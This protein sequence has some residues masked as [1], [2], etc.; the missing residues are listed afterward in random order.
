M[1]RRPLGRDTFCGDM[2]FVPAGDAD[3]EG[4]DDD[5]YLLV[6]THNLREDTSEMLVLSARVRC[7]D[8][9]HAQMSSGVRVTKQFGECKLCVHVV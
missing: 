5:G 4:Q 9:S 6:L 2:S 3:V 1:L 7:G 8:H